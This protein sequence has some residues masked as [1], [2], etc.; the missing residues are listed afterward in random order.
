[1]FYR[2]VKNFKDMGNNNQAQLEQ[3]K[4]EE[5]LKQEKQEEKERQEFEHKVAKEKQ[6]HEYNLRVSSL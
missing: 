4:Q 2:V 5:K 1:M 3:E 6:D